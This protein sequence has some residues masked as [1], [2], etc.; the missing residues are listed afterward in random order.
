MY[1]GGRVWIFTL[2]CASGVSVKCCSVVGSSMLLYQ[3]LLTKVGF[4]L[5]NCVWS[6]KMILSCYDE[7]LLQ[8][9]CSF[10]IWHCTT[11]PPNT[12][13]LPSMRQAA[14][15]KQEE[16][17][18]QSNNNSFAG[19][20]GFQTKPQGMGTARPTAGPTGLSGG[21]HG[22]GM[23]GGGMGFQQ[24][25]AMRG[26]LMGAQQ[27]MVFPQQQQQQ[28]AFGTQGMGMG[29]GM[30]MGGMP[31]QQ[32]GAGMSMGMGMGM[33]QGGG[34]MGSKRGMQAG[35]AAGAGGAVMPGGFTGTGASGSFY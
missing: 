5:G 35:G 31:G 4:V 14:Q 1:K 13:P 18:F 3:L 6:T 27:G 25:H 8:L 32:M 23:M 33:Q 21:M 10:T 2:S 26:G 17:T 34:T 9:I 29:M 11:P 19:L 16:Q 28:Q 22:V 24:Q 12:P 7:F 15:Q 20:D 30:G